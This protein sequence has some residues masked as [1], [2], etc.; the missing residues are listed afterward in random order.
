MHVEEINC[1][2]YLRPVATSTMKNKKFEKVY[3]EWFW[4]ENGFYMNETLLSTID[5]AEVP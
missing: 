3:Q 2:N 1:A 4:F 5:R